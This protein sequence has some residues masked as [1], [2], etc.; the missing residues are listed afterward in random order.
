M[1][2]LVIMLKYNDTC[3]LLISLVIGD[4]SSMQ[5]QNV[6]ILLQRAEH[7]AGMSVLQLASALAI[8]LPYDLKCA[9]G[10][11]GQLVEV[12]LGAT[13]GSKPTQDFPH[14]GIELKTI[15]ITLDCKPA[16]NT[17]V[18][19]LH[20]NVVGQDFAHSNFLNKIK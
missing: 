20:T 1:S 10:F 8:P 13:A 9:K 11:I 15:P 19:A 5:P 3:C 12:A 6:D 18:C 14:L 7:I 2:L 16:E 4:K 17:H